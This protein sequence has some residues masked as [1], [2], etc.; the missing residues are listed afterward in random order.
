[1]DTPTTNKARSQSISILIFS[2]LLMV[3]MAVI[4]TQDMNYIRAFITK[5]GLWGIFISIAVYAALGLTLIPSEP[6][7]LFIGALFGPYIALIIA[8][9]G[10]T[11][12]AL[13]EYYLGKRLG[14]ATNFLEKKEKLPWGLGKLR[15]DSP[16]FLIGARMVPG[17]GPKLVSVTAGVYHVPVLRYL[18][19]SA[20]SV[21]MGAALFAFGGS[22]IGS[23]L[24][25]H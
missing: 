15:A 3:I 19:T 16:L 1:M 11:L 7:T 22:G 24:G 20:L 6:L 14:I 21:F 17:V 2:V 8:G 9:T 25:K 4:I 10:N 23:L 18:W 12:S 5:A 13:V